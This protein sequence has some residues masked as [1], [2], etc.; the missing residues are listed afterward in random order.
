MLAGALLRKLQRENAQRIR[1][2]VI[3]A[4]RTDLRLQLAAPYFIADDQAFQVGSTEMPRHRQKHYNHLQKANRRAYAGP[5]LATVP[6]APLE[7]C[8][9][10]QSGRGVVRRHRRG[11]TPSRRIAL[12]HPSQLTGSP[13]DSS[14]PVD[15]LSLSGLSS[16]LLYFFA[17]S[18]NSHSAWI[19]FRSRN[20]THEN[21]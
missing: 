12:R 19:P 5:R 8:A 1:R 6:I 21:P 10:F 18:F 4:A 13:F 14:L 3:R 20:T 2:C 11:R 7:P 17:F 9:I 15:S 16:G